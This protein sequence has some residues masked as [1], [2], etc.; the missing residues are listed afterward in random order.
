M[1]RLSHQRGWKIPHFRVGR[2][3]LN[4]YEYPPYWWKNQP[5]NL[6]IMVEN[7]REKHL[8][9]NFG[10]KYGQPWMVHIA[11]FFLRMHCQQWKVVVVEEDPVI[12]AE[13]TVTSARVDPKTPFWMSCDSSGSRAH[14]HWFQHWHAMVAYCVV[15]GFRVGRFFVRAQRCLK[16]SHNIPGLRQNFAQITMCSG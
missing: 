5:Q 11:T 12:H 9:L 2:T 14:A 8:P 7:V 16:S 10:W 3:I 6:P 4:Q 1:G 13:T 15:S